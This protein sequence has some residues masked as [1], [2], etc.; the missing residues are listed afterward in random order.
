V[1]SNV[2]VEIRSLFDPIDRPILTQ[3]IQKVIIGEAD[4]SNLMLAALLCE[5]HGLLEDYPAP[6]RRP[7]RA[8]CC[9][10]DSLVY[11]QLLDLSTRLGKPCPPSAAP[12]E[13]L[14]ALQS[15]FPRE[16][17]TLTAITQA[18]IKIRC[19]ELPETY[20]EVQQ[21]LLGWARLKVQ[22]RHMLGA[23]KRRRIKAI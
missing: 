7:L 5:R 6:A 19:A 11:P 21:V 10:P 22:G 2:S 12:L 8:H 9:R 17:N 20:E 3:N 14:P 1:C 16:E 13:F 4:A 23:Q 18:Y 15:L